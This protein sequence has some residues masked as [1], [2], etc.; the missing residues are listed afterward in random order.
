MQIKQVLNNPSLEQTQQ[1]IIAL[2]LEEELA[3]QEKPSLQPH[4]HVAAHHKLR[5][6]ISK[7]QQS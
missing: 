2:E 1:Q 4:L 7:C 5:E 6:T 3:N